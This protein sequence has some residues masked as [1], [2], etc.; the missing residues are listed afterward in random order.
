VPR[1]PHVL[2]VGQHHVGTRAPGTVARLVRL[3]AQRVVTGGLEGAV[4]EGQWFVTRGL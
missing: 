3:K 2:Q 4:G 1:D